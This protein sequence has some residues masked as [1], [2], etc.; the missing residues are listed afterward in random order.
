M[1]SHPCQIAGH[2]HWI[3]TE[4][5]GPIGN[6][7]IYARRAFR[8]DRAPTAALLHI[9]AD[10]FYRL[11]IN[12]ERLGQGPA[13]SDPAWM[14]YDTYDIAD[15]LQLGSNVFAIE[16]NRLIR[17]PGGLLC[18]YHI[19][20]GNDELVIVTD[21]SWRVLPALAWDRRTLPNTPWDHSQLYGARQAPA[22]R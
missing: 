4:Y 15:L 17:V 2:A 20:N 8:L 5:P 1:T 14:S 22:R 11:H 18:Q 9:S 16:A 13:R 21:Q 6:D 3:W 10:T 12:G 7:Y 19:N